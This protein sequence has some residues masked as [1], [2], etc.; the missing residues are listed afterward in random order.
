[1]SAPSADVIRWGRER[2]RTGLWRGDR[3]VAFLAPVPDA[4]LPS[5][6]FLKRCLTTLADRGFSRVV[7][8]ALSPLE[9]GGFLAAGFEITEHLHLLACDLDDLPPTSAG[10]RLQRLTWH[11]RSMVLEVDRAAFAPFW[12]FDLHGLAEALRATP[13][14]RFRA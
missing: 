1:M 3:D 11:T 2:V 5:A 9:Q 6:D 14:T 13:R 8:A 4:P 12:Q 10:L 7:T